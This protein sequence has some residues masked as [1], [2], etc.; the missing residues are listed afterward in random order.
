MD[1][2]KIISTSISGELIQIK[3][4]V[5]ELIEAYHNKN[6]ILPKDNNNIS[7]CTIAGTRLYVHTFK[8]LMNL[9][10]Q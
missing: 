9:I 10:Q 4:T 8:G 6:I 7:V 2:I 1:E 3:C 5:D